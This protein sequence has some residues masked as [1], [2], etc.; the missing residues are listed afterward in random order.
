[1][2]TKKLFICTLAIVF[3]SADA[4]GQNFPT[5]YNGVGSGLD[6]TGTWNDGVEVYTEKTGLM[7]FVGFDAFCVEP[8]QGIDSGDTLIYQTQ[9]P[10]DTAKFDT[11]A[12]LVAAYIASNKTAEDASAIQWAIWETTSEEL[13]APSLID[14]SVRITGVGPNED[15]ANLANQYLANL[16]NFAPVGLTYFTN[17]SFQ[18]VVS[19]NAIPEPTSLGLVALSGLM[20]LRRRRN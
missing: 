20:L 5:T 17:G 19:W 1:M 7:N 6:I 9:L 12:R 3:A 14:G 11:V 2:K 8:F 10:P 4:K 16:N 18:D 13:L 15:I